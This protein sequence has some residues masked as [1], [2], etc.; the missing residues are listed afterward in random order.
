MQSEVDSLILWLLQGCS[1]VSI[2]KGQPA[3]F[4][5][6]NILSPTQCNANTT[7]WWHVA[8]ILEIKVNRMWKYLQSSDHYYENLLINWLF[9]LSWWI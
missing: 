3:A 6:R 4:R 8:L 1:G 5:C 2:L 9:I 7:V